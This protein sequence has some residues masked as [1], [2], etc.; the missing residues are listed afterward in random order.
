MTEHREKMKLEREKR[1]L[2]EC[3]EK[4]RSIDK[5]NERADRARLADCILLN[6]PPREQLKQNKD[7]L[8]REQFFLSKTN[9]PILSNLGRV[10]STRRDRHSQRVLLHKK[11][12]ICE[13][14]DNLMHP[15]EI[16]S[17]VYQM[18]VYVIYRRNSWV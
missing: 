8:S 14:C 18:L 1:Y 16:Q 12:S 2:K 5:G 13:N 15:K 6:V 10:A 4:R 3:R 7:T 17:I 11:A 9:T